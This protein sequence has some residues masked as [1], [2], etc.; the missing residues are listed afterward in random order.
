VQT[1]EYIFPCKRCGK[2]LTEHVVS[3]EPLTNDELE[4]TEFQ[5]RCDKCRWSATRTGAQ[6]ERIF[7]ALKSTPV[8]G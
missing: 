7:S 2:R 3:A 1:Y 4:R 6:A 5:L 8:C